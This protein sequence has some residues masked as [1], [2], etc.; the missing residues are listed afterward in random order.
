MQY[1]LQ[2]VAQT[3]GMS[4]SEH[5]QLISANGL[6]LARSMLSELS[7][8]PAQQITIQTGEHGKPFTPDV[9]YHFN[10]SHSGKYILCAV[11][12]TPIGVDIEKPRAYND[13][14]AKRICTDEEYRYIDG[15][16][17][18]FLEVWTRKEAYAKHIGIGLSISLKTVVV[19][20]ETTLLTTINDTTVFTDYIDGYVFSIVTKS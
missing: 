11:D 8:V 13:R 4:A 3:D 15:D 6:D 14:V 10:I 7:A 1:R 16:S 20:S 18:R 12:D 9:P 17:V 19:A 2:R 5:K